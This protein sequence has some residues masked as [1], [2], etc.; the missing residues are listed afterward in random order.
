[1][2]FNILFKP[3]F[4]RQGLVSGH[5]RKI[6]GKSVQILKKED[7][8]STSFTLDLPVI[9]EVFENPLI[10]DKPICIITVA[11][12][13]RTGKS[14]LLDHMLKHLSTE[15]VSKIN[16]N[17]NGF[18]WKGGM[19]RYTSGVH[20]W[21]DPFI[22]QGATGEE[23]AVFLMDT[24]GTFDHKTTVKENMTVF[25]LST[26]TSSVLMYNLMHVIREDHLQHLQLFTEYGRLALKNSGTTPFQKLQFLVRDWHYPHDAPFG[27]E[28]GKIVLDRL[29]N[30]T[31]E[32]PQEIR[33][34][35]EHIISSF[36]EL[37]CYLFPYPGPK[38]AEDPTFTGSTEEMDPRFA[39]Y[40]DD[41]VSKTLAP[42]NLEPK[43]IAGKIVK[44]REMVDYFQKYLEIFNGD[45]IPE[46][47]SIFETTAEVT[48][49]HA[50]SEA[51]EKYIENM[52][53]LRQS[54]ASQALVEVDLVTKHDQSMQESIDL[55]IEQSKFG[56][57]AFAK[58]YQDELEKEILEKFNYFKRLNDSKIQNIFYKAKEDYLTNMEMKC[59]QEQ[60]L[61]EQ[62]LMDYHI[63]YA[64]EATKKFH[65]VNASGF[66]QPFSDA[67][68]ERLIR[69]IDERF[70]YYQNLNETKIRVAVHHAQD[71]AV[72]N[73]TNLME[74][75]LEG[76]LAIH[77]IKLDYEHKSAKSTS[78]AQFVN[79]SNFGTKFVTA[80]ERSLARDIEDKYSYFKELN[81][82]KQFSKRLKA[83][84]EQLSD[85]ETYKQFWS[86]PTQQKIAGGS[87]ATLLVL[88]ILFGS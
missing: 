18:P 1:M 78:M 3:S 81:A 67:L 64:K 6:H 2:R 27:S 85:N 23:M 79:S 52:G 53:A 21:T 16:D 69:E 84:V 88:R 68:Q 58:H 9:K 61:H 35:R 70:V 43:K 48:N 32:Q 73:Y 65:R 50:L 34:L 17:S 40:L 51:K 77:N 60:P 22:I 24:Q 86:N 38:V 31:E 15:D 11:G 7:D 33:K 45:E 41:F 44:S 62:D 76:P 83:T 71:I 39:K 80:N 25:A 4:Y 14:F 37:D 36:S 82:S 54:A 74:L 66:K 26:M 55:F 49:L 20:L 12:A 42:E 56:G 19:T 59:G 13:M 57:E 29:L 87:V 75:V 46:P 72:D 5:M 63:K 47:K 10:Q 30:T 8:S 28:G